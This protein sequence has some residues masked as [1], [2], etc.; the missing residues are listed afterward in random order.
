ML[1]SPRSASAMK[2]AII[3]VGISGTRNSSSSKARSCLGR[4][5][6][7]VIAD[8]AYASALFY[9]SPRFRTMAAVERT[10]LSV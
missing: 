6:S 1:R 5:S 3:A 7:V 2:R 10:L 9:A 8:E 4:I